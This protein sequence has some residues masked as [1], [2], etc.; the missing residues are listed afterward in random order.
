MEPTQMVD[1]L[2]EAVLGTKPSGMRLIGLLWDAP[3]GI[4][5]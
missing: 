3:I 4:L 2:G 5:E 1:R